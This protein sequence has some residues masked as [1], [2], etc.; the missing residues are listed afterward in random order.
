M[1]Y[2]VLCIT[3]LYILS[4]GLL[5]A[6]CYIKGLE[7]FHLAFKF[8]TSLGF[9]FSSF[10][11]SRMSLNQSFFFSMLPALILCM[12]GDISLALYDTVGKK[13]MF[14]CGLC[15]FLL[16][17]IAFAFSLD[18]ISRLSPIQLILPF[19]GLITTAF[20]IRLKNMN[21]D[22]FRAYILLYS[23][24]VTLLLSKGFSV[25]LKISDSGGI[26]IFLGS[27]FF[28]ISDLII[29]FL[30]FYSKKYCFT[31]F[32][33]LFTYYLAQYFLALSMLYI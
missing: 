4:F 11:F 14:L 33:N 19:L 12:I 10:M 29:L 18:S 25:L 28:F 30:Y 32:L 6:S 26:L 7:K 17:H 27:L 31:R 21:C 9:L 22:G 1:S 24:F 3:L 23:F 2:I 16:G 20:L 13:P 15:S 5:I 8:S